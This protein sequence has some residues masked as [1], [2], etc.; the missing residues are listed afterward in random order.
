MV[1]ASRNKNI[2]TPV[3]TCRCVELPIVFALA[4]LNVLIVAFPCRAT[5]PVFT[6]VTLAAGVD[7]VQRVTPHGDDI[8]GGVMTGGAAAGDFDND[9][10][11]D[12]FVTRLDATD[13]LF[14]NKGTDVSGVHL[15]FENVAVEAFGQSLLTVHSNG[16]AW[17]DVDNDGDLD[18]YVTA[19]EDTR[20]YLYINNGTAPDGSHRGFVEAA[21]TRGAALEKPDL[22][23]GTGVAFGDYDGNGFLDVF[24]GEWRGDLW[25]PTQA[26]ANSRLLRN[27]GT[28]AP[29]YFTDDTEAAGLIVDEVSGTQILSFS[30][31]FVDLDRDGDADLTLA[32]DF[33]RSQ[34]FWNN[35]DGT[36][37]NGTVAPLGSDRNGMGS[38]VGDYDGDG[39]LDWFVTAI[40]QVE[41]NR[42]YRNLGVDAD[43]SPIGFEDATDLA[44]VRNAGWGWGTS[45]LDHD[46]DGDLDLAMTN[47]WKGG[48]FQDDQMRL[49]RNDDGQFA[50]VSNDSGVTD[51][52]Q[53]RGLLTFD[54]DRDGDL[55][56][57]VVNNQDHPILY[58]NDGGNNNDWLQIETVGIVSNRD[59]IGALITVVPDRDDPDHFM[60]RHI[61]GGSN[62]LA[63]NEMIAHF[64]L[65]NLSLSAETVDRVLIRWPSGLTQEFNDVAL[66]SRFVAVE[67]AP[68]PV[69]VML[70][71]VALLVM[72][73]RR[74]RRDAGIGGELSS[75]IHSIRTLS[76]R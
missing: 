29:G 10:W 31:R 28:A 75:G 64:G 45:F 73:Y 72:L 23:F 40:D 18:L 71:G 5:G 13:I 66:N 51:T 4:G 47:G 63:Q 36:F 69:T 56:M 62:Y 12:L 42:L 38:T 43:G 7:Y 24:M 8:R 9:G 35:G 15:G 54:Y 14:R 27:L 65:G 39:H 33:G 57:F 16:A 21:E 61:D 44:G 32:A 20:Y 59:G 58:R 34:L 49:W 53:G 26:P 1:I 60:V 19:L 17:G 50:D 3:R 22:H 46:N 25:N 55:D 11:V 2:T 68:E 67:Q 74:K 76:M 41:G 30:P 6:D 48:L 37:T 70:M 52:R